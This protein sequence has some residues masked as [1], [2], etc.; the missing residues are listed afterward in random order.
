M[1]NVDGSMVAVDVESDGYRVGERNTVDFGS[2]VA[3][4]HLEMKFLW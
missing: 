4:W 2:L 3:M 1:V